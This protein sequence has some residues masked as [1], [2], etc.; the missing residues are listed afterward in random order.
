MAARGGVPLEEDRRLPH[1]VLIVT[2]PS[3][4]TTV[5]RKLETSPLRA[6]M[7]QAIQQAHPWLRYWELVDEF[8]STIAR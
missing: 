8:R 1:D 3:G 7:R 2:W 4:R 6:R 5:L